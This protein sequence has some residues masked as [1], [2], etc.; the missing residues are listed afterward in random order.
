MLNV[1][2]R[3]R[4]GERSHLPPRFTIDLFETVLILR[5]RDCAT[6][7]VEK[8]G[9][10]ARKGP[11]ESIMISENE[12]LVEICLGALAEAH[13]TLGNL[14]DQGVSEIRD[15]HVADISTEGDL[16][17]SQALIRYFG[18]QGMPAQ[19]Y[20]EE[21]GKVEIGKNPIYTITFDDLDGTDNYFRGRGILPYCTVVTI[22]DC[23]EPTFQDAAV[24]GILEHNSGTFWHAIREGGS[25]RNGVS[26]RTSERRTLDRR[27]LI[28]IDHYASSER[29]TQVFELYP[30]A[31]VKDFGSAALHLAGVSSGLFDG[32]LSF[33]QK[34][35]EL[36]AGYLLVTESGGFIRDTKNRDIQSVE[37]LFDERYSIVATAT[38]QLGEALLSKIV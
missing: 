3:K 19:I 1:C 14:G 24:A 4:G 29:M 26:V 33:S 20:S 8:L 6:I 25:F 21:S 2:A 27:A 37:Y 30:Q 13:K 36:G 7:I 35:H 18:E 23:I 28:T 16:A 15:E 38:N 9:S 17:V 5:N 10:L 22:F 11:H 32:Y 34:A 12:H 31:W